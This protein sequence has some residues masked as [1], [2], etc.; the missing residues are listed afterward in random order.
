[1]GSLSSSGKLVAIGLSMSALALVA[2]REL[3]DGI[4]LLWSSVCSF[5]LIRASRRM[6]TEASRSFLLLGAAAFIMLAGIVVRSIHGNAV[7]V[8][9]PL[10]SP[11]DLLHLPAYL[12]FLFIALQIRRARSRGRDIDAWLDSI[13]F[14]LSI[15]AVL[16]GLFLGDFVLNAEDPALTVGLHVS[17]NALI[18]GMLAVVLRIGV[19]PGPRSKSYYLLGAGCSAFFVADIY[20]TW[21]ATASQTA[22]VTIALSPMVYGFCAASATHP[23]APNLLTPDLK[24]ETEST[25]YRTAYV[26]FALVAPAIVAVAAAGASGITQATALIGSIVAAVLVSIRVWRLLRSEDIA[27]QKERRL[28][29]ELGELARLDSVEDIRAALPRASRRIL[30]DHSARLSG[31]NSSAG[32]SITQLALPTPL[33]AEGRV[34]TIEPALTD[35][36]D[37]RLLDSL[38]R[39][40]GHIA[41]TIN[42]RKEIEKQ[43]LATEANR[44]IA[45]N[46][47][48]FRALVQN[49]SDMVIVIDPLT[50]GAVTY[51]SE[52]C[53]RVLGYPSEEFVG[54]DLEWVTHEMDWEFAREYMMATLTGTESHYKHEVRGLH[55]DGSI[56]LL[57]CLMTDMSDID[58]VDGV[59]INISDVTEKRAL[60]RH[61]RDAETTDPLTLLLNRTAFIREVDVSIRR[62]SVSE[63]SVA[64]AII[65]I[66]DFRLINE[67]YGTATADA[68][69]IELAHRVRQA[70]RID[71]IVAR[72]NGDEFGILMPAGYSSHEAEAVVERVLLEL[73]D[74]VAVSGRMIALRATAGLVFDERGQST[75]LRMLQDAD[76][77][78]DA[79]KQTQRGGLVRFEEAMGEEVSE[80]VELR[81]LL[82]TAIEEDGL[83]LAYQ[84]IVNME[85]GKIVSLEALSRWHDDVRGDISP[86]TFIPI[87]ESTGLISKLGEWALRTACQDMVMWSKQGLS[88]F[89][90][91]VNMSGHQLR[92]EN[93]I[94]TV[95]RI[96]DDTKVDPTRVTIE[97]T[98][99]VLIDDT[100]FIAE[101]IRA[102]RELGLRLSIDDFGTGYSSLS[103]LRRYEF[104][105]L[106]IDR[107]FVIP[108]ASDEN[109]RE[110]EIVNAMIK[111]A[112]ALGAKTVA[113]GIEESEEYAVLRTL[114]CDHA[115]GF[116]FHYP[117]ETSEVGDV[118]RARPI[119]V[120]AA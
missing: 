63:T 75:G 30:E 81:N 62:A 20:A 102:L 112:Q 26:L 64:L 17:Y 23:T 51:I 10:P 108:L 31:S 72:L 37:K 84:P 107:S 77:A 111:L 19:T 24:A 78:L 103:Y 2:P 36:H 48:K 96:L 1:M 47:R 68:L 18:F 101:R 66:D 15:W 58:G 120:A 69:L 91:S 22:F 89:T 82:R 95:K 74:P 3:S 32:S 117:L 33:Q 27:R 105:V 40:A 79:A 28:G 114:G 44:L 113:E 106:K 88:D 53:E 13:S 42:A 5:L 55:S 92:E 57:E 41:S 25:N 49:A 11:A 21:A 90:V 46:E 76:T 100:D 50:D 4:V 71:D 14:T 52:A 12:M 73:A 7:G 93:V 67:G 6:N 109:K 87:A 80:R 104:D 98:E 99:S 65:N 59:V 16:W 94:A 9:Q 85:T 54:R 56:R 115:Q 60:E 116:L 119:D 38:C 86:S 83:R 110:R 8:E 70:V 34:L 39:D 97:I 118:L 61:L 29:V 35:D 43:R 45:T